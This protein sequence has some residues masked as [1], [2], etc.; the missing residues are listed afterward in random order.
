MNCKC[1][2]LALTVGLS[3]ALSAEEVEL[4]NSHIRMKLEKTGTVWKMTSL[5]RVS[6]EDALTAT[7]TQNTRCK[8]LE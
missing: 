4:K 7:V 2:F 8:W 3:A 6:G 5:A 1:L